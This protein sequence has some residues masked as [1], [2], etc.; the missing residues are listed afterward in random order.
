WHDRVDRPLD[1]AGPGH[2]ADAGRRALVWIQNDRRAIRDLCGVDARTGGTGRGPHLGNPRNT[3]RDGTDDFQHRAAAVRLH[4][5][6]SRSRVAGAGPGLLAAG[7]PGLWCVVEPA[8]RVG[9]N[10]GC[11]RRLPAVCWTAS[12]NGGAPV[13]RGRH[14]DSPGTVGTHVVAWW[15]PARTP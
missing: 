5:G 9:R 8:D 15:T 3:A 4:S 7:T 10:E 11:R 2:V 14:G 1:R 12:I 13:C 6:D